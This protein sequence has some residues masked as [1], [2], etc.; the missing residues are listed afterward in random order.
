MGLGA[1]MALRLTQ[2]GEKRHANRIGQH[3]QD[4][5]RIGH[6]TLLGEDAWMA[7]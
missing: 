3:F 2:P 7:P 6:V 1:E 4:F 5:I